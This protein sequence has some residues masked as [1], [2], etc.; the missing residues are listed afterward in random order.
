MTQPVEGSKI[1]NLR[2]FRLAYEVSLEVHRVS[3]SWPKVE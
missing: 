1:E 2:V 3:L